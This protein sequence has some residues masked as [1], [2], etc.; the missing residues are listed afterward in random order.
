[1]NYI[2]VDFEWNQTSYGKGSENRKIPFEIIADSYLYV[3]EGVMAEFGL[4]L[5][6][7]L[8]ARAIVVDA[9]SAE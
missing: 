8:Q 6:E 7:D 4:T 2:V 9:E 1:M 5:P 3:N